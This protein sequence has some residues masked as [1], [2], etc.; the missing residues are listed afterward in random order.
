MKCLRQKSYHQSISCLNYFAQKPHAA[1][2]SPVSAHTTFRKGER[3]CVVCSLEWIIYMLFI[4]TEFAIYQEFME[5]LRE[6]K[7]III[8]FTYNHIPRIAPMSPSCIIYANANMDNYSRGVRRRPLC[9][10]CGLAGYMPLFSRAANEKLLW[11]TFEFAQN[12]VHSDAAGEKWC[13]REIT[14][15]VWLGLYP[16]SRLVQWEAALS[17]AFQIEHAV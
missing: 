4:C 9:E 8:I 2:T 6:E 12:V 7:I 13:S 14:K 11:E 3:A 1:A 5:K 10:W 16:K 17:R 15:P